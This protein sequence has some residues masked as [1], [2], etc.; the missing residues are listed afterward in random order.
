MHKQVASV[1]IM[2]ESESE[3]SFQKAFNK[4]RNIDHIINDSLFIRS[5]EVKTKIC[6]AITNFAKGFFFRL[7]FFVDFIK[8]AV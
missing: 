7:S 1:R 6:V 2:F 5:I 3:R 4:F 8:N